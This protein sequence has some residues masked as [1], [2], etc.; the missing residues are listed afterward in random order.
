M[1]AGFVVLALA[2]NGA[3]AAVSFWRRAVTRGG[4]VAGFVTGS[5][6]LIIGGFTYWTI[7]ML[8]FVTASLVTRVGTAQ[9]TRLSA[10]HEKGGRRDWA[11]VV[12][13]GGV[14]LLAVALL[15][16]TRQPPFGVAAAAA[17][18][19]ANADT[20]ASELGVLSKR[21]PR[22]I[23]AWNR[24]PT[25]TS[26]GVSAVGTAATIVGAAIVALWFGGTV[27]FLE[28][29]SLGRTLPEQTYVGLPLLNPLVAGAVVLLAGIIGSLV[30]SLLGATL[31]AHYLTAANATTERSKT[32]GV[33]NRRV[34]GLAFVN[35]DMVNLLSTTIAATAAGLVAVLL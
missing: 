15:G 34:R 27:A 26:G 16:L 23:V 11:Q 8:F 14:A 29:V 13:N 3:A 20:W 12:A 22:S 35:N 1:T 17:L 7:L 21:R 6:I 24:L 19:S 25:G 5:V 33:P 2:L 4:A 9:K 28:G 18:A 32:D 31:Q 10:V 30:D